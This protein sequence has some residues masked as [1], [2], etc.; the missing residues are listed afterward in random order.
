[1]EREED[2]VRRS[3]WGMGTSANYSGFQN[4]IIAALKNTVNW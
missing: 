4:R 3:K 2:E 1:M